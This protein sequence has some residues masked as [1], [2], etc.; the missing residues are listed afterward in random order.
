MV[1]GS[2]VE[3]VW[4][5]LSRTTSLARSQ[6][7]EVLLTTDGRKIVAQVGQNWG[8]VCEMFKSKVVLSIVLGGF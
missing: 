6:A 2:K 4:S 8:K 3:V 5:S 1:L 7:G